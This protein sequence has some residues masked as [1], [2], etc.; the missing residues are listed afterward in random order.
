RGQLPIP[1]L[2]RTRELRVAQRPVEGSHAE[3]RSVQSYRRSE[4]RDRAQVDARRLHRK[5]LK[6]HAVG[7]L[8]V[9]FAL[10]ADAAFGPS[11]NERVA[12]RPVGLEGEA[13]E[14]PRGNGVPAEPSR[15]GQCIEEG[16]GEL[17]VE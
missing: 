9:H 4:L 3:E 17:E 5:R 14:R 15:E 1:V 12:E 6:S 8:E 7:G 11:R 16:P 13:C 2:E 10:P